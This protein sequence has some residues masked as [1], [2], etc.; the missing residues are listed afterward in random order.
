MIV[1]FAAI[2]AAFG[3]RQGFLI[4]ALSLTGFALGAFIG[5]R[6]GP[7]LL[8]R[9]A[10][11]PY[12]PAFGLFGAVIAGAVFA[13]GF[14]GIALR[15]RSAMIVPG[16]GTLDGALGAVLGARARARRSC[17]SRPRWRRRRRGPG[18]CAPTSSARRSC[19]A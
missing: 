13:R 1:A 7:L 19:A 17:G 10:S 18:S 4:G 8:P 14:E 3:F 16:L 9:G 5:T 6:V 15:L 2:L 12:A 11:S